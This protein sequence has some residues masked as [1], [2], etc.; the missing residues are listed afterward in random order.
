MRKISKLFSKQKQTVGSRSIQETAENNASLGADTNRFQ[1]TVNLGLPQSRPQLP[2]LDTKASPSLSEVPSRGLS[3][4]LGSIDISKERS[5]VSADFPSS[6]P[7]FSAPSYI[8]TLQAKPTLGPAASVG[9]LSFSSLSSRNSLLERSMHH[10]ALSLQHFH[11][12]Y[13]RYEMRRGDRS[14][15]CQNIVE[16][17]DQSSLADPVDMATAL[18]KCIDETIFETQ[19]HGHEY[20]LTSWIPD[21]LKKLHPMMKFVMRVIGPAISVIT[22]LE[23]FF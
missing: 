1:E 21:F 13:Q 5:M 4:P 10:F 7:R 16:V 9:S 3:S 19:R 6:S 14:R 18:Q 17:L 12:I 8:E 23:R 20:L 22:Q 11:Q 15:T 2:S